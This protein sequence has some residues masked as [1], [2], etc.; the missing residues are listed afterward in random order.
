MNNIDRRENGKKMR[1]SEEEEKDWIDVESP[2]W[3]SKLIFVTIEFF[4]KLKIKL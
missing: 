4:S 3:Y 2:P 1:S